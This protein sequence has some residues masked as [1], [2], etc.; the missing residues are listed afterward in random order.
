VGTTYQTI[1]ATGDLAPLRTV[2]G[3]DPVI[4]PVGPARWAVVP[5]GKDG[6][7]DTEELALRLSRTTGGYAAA[8]QVF[9]SDVLV[10]HIFRDGRPHHEYLSDQGFVVEMWDD[11]DNELLVDPLGRE[12]RP[13]EEPSSGAFGADPAAFLPLGVGDIDATRLGEALRGPEMMANHQHHV[14]LEILNLDAAPLAMDY[15]EAR[16][17]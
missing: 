9:D 12:Y 6:Y 1:L 7:A 14:I 16:R 15:D 8:F 13:G 2:A 3:D 17:V 5:K 4:L 11:D 10:A